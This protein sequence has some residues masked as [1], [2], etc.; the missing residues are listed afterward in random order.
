MEGY[1]KMLPSGIILLWFGAIVDIPP[2]Y[3]ICDGNNGTPDLRNNFVVGA[4]LSFV[5]G[6]TGGSS[7]HTHGF[8]SDGHNHT[9]PAGS[10]IE[11]GI[12]SNN[13]VNTESDTGTTGAAVTF[14][15]YHALA[16][17]MKT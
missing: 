13:T 10:D 7:F 11:A 9:I 3:V 4:G 12:G 8:T 5:V 2:D 17:I 6:A 15:P 16:Y 14:P 1:D